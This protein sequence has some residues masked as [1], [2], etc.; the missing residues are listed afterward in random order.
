MSDQ[1][2]FE[3]AERAKVQSLNLKIEN[4]TDRLEYYRKDKLN[5]IFE[6]TDSILQ[7]LEYEVRQTALRSDPRKAAQKTSLISTQE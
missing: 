1:S 6:N 3:K 4:V 7:G 5:D 2:T